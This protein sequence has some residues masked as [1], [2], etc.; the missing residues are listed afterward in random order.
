VLLIGGI[1]FVFFA[2][3]TTDNCSD[4]QKSLE[5][6]QGNPKVEILSPK[7]PGALRKC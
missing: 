5:K 2:S 4:F 7:S 6:S 1:Y 3:V